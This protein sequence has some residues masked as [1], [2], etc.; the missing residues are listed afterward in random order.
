[1][2]DNSTHRTRAAVILPRLP[3][4]R[5]API[6]VQSAE[7]LGTVA[8]LCTPGIPPRTPHRIRLALARSFHEFSSTKWRTSS[9]CGLAIRAAIA[10]EQLLGAERAP[11]EL[12][13]SAEWRKLALTPAHRRDRSRAWR[14]YC[15]ESFCDTAAWLWSGLAR[16]PEF[17]LAAQY[18]AAGSLVSAVAGQ[19][20]V[21]DIMWAGI[22]VPT[23]RSSAAVFFAIL[24]ACLLAA[25]S[26]GVRAA[27]PVKP[28]KDR[29]VAPDFLLKTPMAR[30]C[31]SPTTR[32]GGAARFLR[33]MVRPVQNRDSL[34]HRI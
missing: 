1:L 22:I 13:W 34:V 28:E 31:I 18:R 15:C 6:R 21:V 2:F 25:C 19:W 23:T 14:E 29:R 7:G 32:E 20:A 30:P 26:S 16:H 10:Y 33:H 5:G 4:L 8:G 27:E 9:G 24:V 17:T 3:E 12:G 11:G